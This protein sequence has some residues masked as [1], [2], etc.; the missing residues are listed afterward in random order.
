MRSFMN[1]LNSIGEIDKSKLK[2]N[3]NS[4]NGIIVEYYLFRKIINILKE[5]DKEHIP[6]QCLCGALGVVENPVDSSRVVKSSNKLLCD[7]C[8]K[9]QISIRETLEGDHL[10]QKGIKQLNGQL[11][12]A[13]L[14][15][16]AELIWFSWSAL[17]LNRNQLVAIDR[18]LTLLHDNF[19]KNEMEF[20]LE[21]N[22]LS[23]FC[24]GKTYHHDRQVV[25]LLTLLTHL[26]ELSPFYDLL[27]SILQIAD[28]QYAKSHSFRT[29]IG[30]QITI[31]DCQTGCE[32]DAPITQKRLAIKDFLARKKLQDMVKLFKRSFDVDIR[33]DF[34]HAEYKIRIDG[35]ELPRKGRVITYEELKQKVFGAFYIVTWVIRFVEKIREDFVRS[36]CYI[37][38]GYK[39]IPVIKDDKMAIRVES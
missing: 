5:V 24:V 14:H 33:N 3:S 32:M 27:L 25:L 15:N 2:F 21:E 1:I 39:L 22:D 38:E 26:I 31:K 19:L 17:S 13:Q 20:L 8:G 35:I 12:H 37:G 23:Q 34:T 11:A 10:I 16:Q 36:G 6:F 30:C 7:M 18:A 29:D 4:N 9:Y 28:D